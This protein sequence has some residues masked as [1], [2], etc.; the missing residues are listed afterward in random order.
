MKTVYIGKQRADGK[1]KV[2]LIYAGEPNAFGGTYP[3]KRFNK[4]KTLEQIQAYQ[5]FEGDT[6]H[7]NSGM[8]D[9][10]FKGVK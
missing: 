3:E 10:I 5:W 2:Q 9:E 6:L 7:N 8:P 4:L 1:F